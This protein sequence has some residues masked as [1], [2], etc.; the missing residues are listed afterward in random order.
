MVRRWLLLCILALAASSCAGRASAAHYITLAPTSPIYKQIRIESS[1]GSD[2]VI[3]AFTAQD[4][5]VL[6]LQLSAAGSSLVLEQ[7]LP[8]VGLTKGSPFDAE[9]LRKA[10][11]AYGIASTGQ[12]KINDAQKAIDLILQV[13]VPGPDVVAVPVSFEVIETN[14]DV[15]R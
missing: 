7:A 11:T 1:P 5:V 12:F 6:S 10:I 4:G 9:A 13:A 8:E 2:E 3:A 15:D 14:L